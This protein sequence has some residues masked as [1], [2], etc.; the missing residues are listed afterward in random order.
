M[1]GMSLA[2]NVVDGSFEDISLPDGGIDV[3]WSQ[4]AILHS[5]NR[6]RVF[7]E[8]HRV[9]AKGGQF[10]FT[11]P[12]QNEDCSTSMLQPILDRIHLDSLGSVTFYRKVA[13]ELGFK[14]LQILDL[15]KHLAAHY[16]R[17]LQEIDVSY[18]NLIRV[19]SEE[20]IKK[21]K[22]G[23]QHWIDGGQT[24]NLTWGILH[25]QKI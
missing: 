11:D 8:V 16:E 4:D 25:F 20:Y 1:Q 3:V 23:L 12:M 15:S 22:V 24:G 10:I 6:R 17:V 19:C 14:E 2:L 5:G 9:L 13:S 18:N 7:E 21:M